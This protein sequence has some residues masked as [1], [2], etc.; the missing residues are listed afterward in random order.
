MIKNFALTI[1]LSLMLFSCGKSGVVLPSATGTRYEILVV[2]DESSWKAPSGRALVALL[3]QDMKA[4]PQAE[5]VMSIIHCQPKEFG[6]L[7]KPTRNILI[8][9]INP[10]FEIPNITY[11]RNTW[12]QPQTVVKIEAANDSA[13]T[14]LI[15]QSGNKILDYF[16]TTERNRQIEIGKNYLNHKAQKEIEEMF[17]IQV[18]I[19]SELSKVTKG[20]DFYWVTN[21]HHHTRK[22]MVIYSYPYR[23]KN[24]FT[25]EYLI[26][27]RDSVMKANIPGEFEGS[28]M[29]TELVNYQPIFREINVNNTYCAELSGLWRMF[30][31]GSMGGPFYSH[32]RVDEINQRV[33]TV[34]GFV[35]APGTKKRNHIRQ[36]EAAVYT[37]KL[38]QEINAIKEVSVVAEKNNSK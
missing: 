31:G 20:T 29:G 19:P 10:R 9:E 34:E 30:N 26:A 21:D 32:T 37:V 7:L 16:L 13:L 5:P 27:K 38:P 24:T 1:V 8:T 22:D 6:N 23:D 33:I 12:S 4:L 18:D 35:F 14:T 17:D 36:L 25:K 15:K 3:D 2:I 11:A 28:Y